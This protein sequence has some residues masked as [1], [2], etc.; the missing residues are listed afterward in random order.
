M[1]G[2]RRT[3]TLKGKPLALLGHEIKVGEKAPNF[4][5]LVIDST[6]VELSQSEGKVRLLSV[7]HSL[8]TN[9]CDLQTQRFEEGA[10]K[11]KDIESTLGIVPM[12]TRA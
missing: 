10:A 4:K 6:N 5:L 12:F 8:D 7:V 1:V 9:V 11:F 3:V 2:T